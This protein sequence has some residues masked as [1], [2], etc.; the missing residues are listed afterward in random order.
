MQ[1]DY[2]IEKIFEQ[3]EN[4]LI[5]SMKRT[6]WSHKED[7]KTKGFNWPQWQALKLKQLED[8]RKNNQDIF[9][10]YNQ[11]IKYAT[12]IQMKKQFREGA[13]RTNKQ[14][15]KAGVINKEDS[16]LSGSFFGLNDRKIKA[17]M[18]STTKDI[19]DVK[20]ATLRMAN[21]Q[22]RQIIYKAEV[23]ANTGAKT[24]QQAIDMA[25]HDFLARGF[26]CIEYKNGTRH[27][28]ADYCDM[29]IR[30]ANKRAN[31]MGEG[32]M[33]KKLGIT[34]CY[35]SKHGGACDKCS[36]WQGR[37]YIDD[38][39]A[40]GK[41]ED[42][43][44]PLLSTAIN[45]GLW[46]PR[47]RHGRSIYYEGVNDEPKEVTQALSGE[48]EDEYTQAL[49]RQKRQYER[50]ALGSLL[51]EN[52]LN[53]Q[54]KVNELQNQIE[55]SKINK[56]ET[57]KEFKKYGIERYNITGVDEE[58]AN[59]VANRL[60]KYT[61]EYKTKLKTV[62]ITSALNGKTLEG[63][64]VEGYGANLK[65]VR[66]ALKHE[67]STVDHEFFHTMA[68][69]KI[70]KSLNVNTEF[71]KEIDG[72]KRRYTKE[73]K[74]IDKKL[75]VEKSISAKDA[76]KLKERILIAGKNVDL[77]NYA[78]TNLDEFS[79]VSF[80]VIKTGQSN[81]KYAQEVVDA[82]D[83]YF[84]KEELPEFKSFLKEQE[85]IYT[86]KEIRQIAKETKKI[87]DNYTINKSKWSGKIIV[88]NRK[89]SAKLWNCNIEIESNTS[90]HTILHEQLHAHSISYFDKETYKK[91]KRIEEATVELYTKE[92]CKKENIINIKSEYDNWVNNLKKINNKL[93][94][95]DNDFDFAKELFNI[96]VN[97]RLDFLENEI[98]QY[99]KDK[100]IDE[101]IELTNLMEELYVK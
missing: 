81:S 28:I 25:T 101:A 67:L 100:T 71:W 23:Y 55:N 76:N 33:M 22:Y 3:I 96:P 80:E 51:P 84:K 65:L 85:R 7:E 61:K 18:K 2:D 14:A 48:H 27:N 15:I 19:N 41:K 46:H 89:V 52:V 88:S 72:I 98:E 47:C 5:S 24:V 75:L 50:L 34:T 54:N 79:A 9:K 90:P 37:V 16:Q 44:Y 69:Y 4:D 62:D 36:P 13:S 91:Y 35:I 39:W 66:G 1:N 74:S 29:A 11:D 45:G 99:L 17:L 6:F 94:I 49:Q 87:A 86:K 95:K 42:G 63:G 58:T 93:K 68:Q 31:L 83:K 8:F 59:E 43:R 60:I 12:K 32:E 26:N 20:Y 53:Y 10:N 56:N 97:K 73:L 92:I 40:G 57:I 70:D 21:D 30:T 82:I 64:H 77:N 78:L 38:V